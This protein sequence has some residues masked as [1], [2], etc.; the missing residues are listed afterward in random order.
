M[1]PASSPDC[2]QIIQDELYAGHPAGGWGCELRHDP[3][4][5]MLWKGSMVL[6]TKAPADATIATLEAMRTQ[7]GVSSQQQAWI[8]EEMSNIRA[9]DRGEREAAYFIDFEL[10]T[11]RNYAILHDL[12]IEHEGRVAQIDHLII[13]RMAD[14]ILIESKNISTAVRINDLGE[15]EVK[16]RYGW[17]GMNSPVEQ[18]RRH[19]TVLGDFLK[20]SGLLPRRLGFQLQ[21]E[22]HQWVLV[23]AQCS[24]GRNRDAAQIVKMDMFGARM[25]DWINRTSSGEVLKMAKVISSETLRDF[26]TALA[27]KHR[28]IAF[29]YAAKFRITSSSPSFAGEGVPNVARIQRANAPVATALAGPDNAAPQCATCSTEVETKVATF[30]R[31]NAKRFGRKVY[32]RTCQ[33][34]VARCC[35]ECAAPVDSKTA[36]FC[37]FN[38]KRLAKR[39]LCRECQTTNGVAMAG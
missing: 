29:D 4:E 20:A 13:G 36:A 14:I 28:P 25:K 26:A 17:K 6:K 35:D 38:S 22:L 10:G 39:V 18:N 23:P 34:T 5:K 1:P 33:E 11:S 31:L 15:F 8:D 21:P 37:R 12:R 24:L 30:C 32:C 3:A 19:A 2:S 9:G 7:P 16:T 27:Q